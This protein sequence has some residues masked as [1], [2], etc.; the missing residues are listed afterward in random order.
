MSNAIAVGTY[1]NDDGSVGLSLIIFDGER[2][3]DIKMVVNHALY[4]MSQINS[5]LN[6]IE[7]FVHPKSPQNVRPN[8]PLQQK[9]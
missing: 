9:R 5:A 2:Y 4:L 3:V 7:K 8:Q 1:I 6:F